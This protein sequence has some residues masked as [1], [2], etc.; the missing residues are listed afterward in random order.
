[1][2]DLERAETFTGYNNMRDQDDEIMDEEH[3]NWPV[4][5]TRIFCFF[6]LFLIIIC[7][8]LEVITPRF[9]VLAAIICGF[10]ILVVVGT[11]VDPRKWWSIIC[12][13]QQDEP[14]PARTLGNPRPP[15]N[16]GTN[17]IV[18]PL[19]TSRPGT[20]SPYQP[21]RPNNV[22]IAPTVVSAKSENPIQMVERNSLG[23]S[24]STTPK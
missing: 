12:R 11:Y 2:S 1:M 10:L 23:T 15:G 9:L 20:V 7:V 18:N 21:P 17:M 5:L 6:L 16:D 24:P 3:W 13:R 8:I 4:L 19:A 22:G 14:T